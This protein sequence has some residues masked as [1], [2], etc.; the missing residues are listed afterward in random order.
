LQPWLT[1][2]TPAVLLEKIKLPLFFSPAAM[3]A[4]GAE[5]DL[6]S[7][8]KFAERLKPTLNGNV[9]G[10]QFSSRVLEMT[11]NSSN[12]FGRTHVCAFSVVK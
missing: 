10:T 6:G 9:S 1:V 7:Q 3:Q 5:G 8:R 4:C 12:I 2:K 11:S